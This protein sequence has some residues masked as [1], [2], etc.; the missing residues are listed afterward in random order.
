MFLVF[1]VGSTSLP[2]SK[3]KLQIVQMIKSY[4]P[5]TPLEYVLVIWIPGNEGNEEV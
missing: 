3:D 2:A 5:P 4:W 1:A